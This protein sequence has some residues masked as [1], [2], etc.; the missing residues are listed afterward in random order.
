MLNDMCVYIQQYSSPSVENVLLANKEF[1]FC[2][3]RGCFDD[4]ADLNVPISISNTSVLY[5]VTTFMIMMYRN[6]YK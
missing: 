4:V 6:V 2:N 1:T 3:S 5:R